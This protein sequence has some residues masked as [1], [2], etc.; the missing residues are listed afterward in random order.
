MWLDVSGHS[1]CKRRRA[2]RRKRGERLQKRLRMLHKRE[3]ASERWEEPPHT[4]TFFVHSHRWRRAHLRRQASAN[5]CR[6]DSYTS[7]QPTYAT[8]KA[9]IATQKHPHKHPAG[10]CR[11]RA[12]WSQWAANACNKAK[13]RPTEPTAHRRK[14]QAAPAGKHELRPKQSHMLDTKTQH[15]KMAPHP[16]GAP[17]SVTKRDSKRLM[18]P[19][20]QTPPINISVRPDHRANKSCLATT[21]KRR[22]IA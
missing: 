6:R 19:R 8:Q 22:A 2:L 12:T 21:A 3:E 9:R 4:N 7:K 18:W 13:P 15:T 17:A 11:N 20:V 10:G 16:L 14:G 5:T 1:R